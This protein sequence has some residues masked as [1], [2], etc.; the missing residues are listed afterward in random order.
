[1]ERLFH[2]VFWSRQTDSNPRPADYKSAALPTVLCRHKQRRQRAK[3]AGTRCATR[4]ILS[5]SFA[6]CQSFRAFC[7]AQKSSSVSCSGRAMG[8]RPAA[9]SACIT[10]ALGM[11][12]PGRNGIRCRFAAL[13]EGRPHQLEIARLVRRFHRGLRTQHQLDDRAG[14]LRRREEAARLH[15]E[16]QAG[17]G[18]IGHAVADGSGGAGCPGR[19]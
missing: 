17:L 11:P 18:V 14:H 9:S 4:N 3:P 16:Q 10:R 2:G 19:R 5:H 7:R 6:A 1:M 8:E 15:G 12:Q 13:A